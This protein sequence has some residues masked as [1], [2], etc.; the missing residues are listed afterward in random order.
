LASLLAQTTLSAINVG[1]INAL[2]AQVQQ[3]LAAINP[4]HRRS[5]FQS[6]VLNSTLMLFINKQFRHEYPHSCLPDMTNSDHFSKRGN[7]SYTVDFWRQS[8]KHTWMPVAGAQLSG[9]G[10]GSCVSSLFF[11]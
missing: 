8:Y 3:Q 5:I 1:R 10:L 4:L 7:L 2:F 6:P 11:K 9:S